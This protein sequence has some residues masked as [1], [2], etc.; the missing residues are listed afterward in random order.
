MLNKTTSQPQCEVAVSFQWE[1]LDF[2]LVCDAV[3]PWIHHLSRRIFTIWGRDVIW[4]SIQRP[5]ENPQCT[6]KTT[7]SWGKTSAGSCPCQSQGNKLPKTLSFFGKA[8][9]YSSGQQ[10]SPKGGTCACGCFR[11]VDQAQVGVPSHSAS[12]C[13]A[14]GEW[15]DTDAESWLLLLP[16]SMVW[17]FETLCPGRPRNPASLFQTHSDICLVFHLIFQYLLKRACCIVS[18]LWQEK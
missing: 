14:F 8:C 12:E 3:L 17:I 13:T 1:W 9:V 2:Q 10:G 16:N 6:K 5:S 15:K 7:I 4:S 11:V 18:W